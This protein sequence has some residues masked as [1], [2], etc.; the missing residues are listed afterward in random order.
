MKKPRTKDDYWYN[1]IA[2]S[3]P[4]KIYRD[5]PNCGMRVGIPV[6]YNTKFCYM[7]GAT[8]YSS[9]NRNENAR[10]KYR[11]FKELEKKG[12]KVNDRTKKKK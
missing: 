11:F 12:I 7:C 4:E 6:I 9:W 3:E 10:K 5:C 2:N 8:I 1:R